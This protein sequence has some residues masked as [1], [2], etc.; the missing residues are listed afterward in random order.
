MNMREFGGLLGII[1]SSIFIKGL[2]NPEFGDKPV[3]IKAIDKIVSVVKCL[4]ST[5]TKE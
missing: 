5:E 3:D 4:T 2:F 1:G